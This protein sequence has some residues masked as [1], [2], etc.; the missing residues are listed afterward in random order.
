MDKLT[1][2]VNFI[3]IR[4]NL[5]KE[6]MTKTEEVILALVEELYKNV[7]TQI[8]VV[9]KEKPRL[10]IKKEYRNKEVNDG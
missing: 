10:P 4:N 9:A 1:N 5:K 7:G 2:D 6:K 8:V 3:D